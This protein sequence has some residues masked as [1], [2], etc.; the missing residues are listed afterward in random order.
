MVNKEENLS[1][2]D[3][4]KE[5]RERIIKCCIALTLCFLPLIY[6]SNP[7]YQFVSKPLQALLPNT[8]S[9][10]ATEV[11][12]P[13][14]TPI[15]LTFFVSLLIS[16][17][18]ILYQVWG[19]ISP[20]MYKHEKRFA[21]SILVSS[22]TLFYLGIIF[23]YAL[24]FPLIFGFFTSIAPE[25][26]MVM[27]DISSYLDFVLKMFV[28]FSFSFEIPII[29]III[30][31]AGITSPEALAKKR[32]YIILSC[33]IMGMLLT[34]PDAISQILLAVPAWILFELGLLSSRII[35]RKKNNV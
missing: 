20:G 10:I 34:P 16:I 22:I 33:F 29:I 21:Y 17:P 19:F 8:S 11:A 23:T 15:K 27:T 9:M 14:F 18:Y 31:W 4:L 35:N 7:I 3:H 1:L 12:S 30:T 25:G 2:F 13:F 5:L 6:L 26:I 24:V 32:P 28:A